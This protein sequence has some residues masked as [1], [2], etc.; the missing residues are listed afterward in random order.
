MSKVI[1]LRQVNRLIKQAKSKPVVEVTEQ[2]VHEYD[3]CLLMS[4][5]S[6]AILYVRNGS[7]SYT[8]KNYFGYRMDVDGRHNHW[9]RTGFEGKVLKTAVY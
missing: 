6:G 7:I 9:I 8:A 5:Y 3:G 2:N 4:K 1:Q